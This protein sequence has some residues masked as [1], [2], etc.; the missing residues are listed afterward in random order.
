[1]KEVSGN[2]GKKERW[3]SAEENRH[4]AGEEG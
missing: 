1:M 3:E 4:G 2:L